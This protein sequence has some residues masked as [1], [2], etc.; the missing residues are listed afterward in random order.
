MIDN[1]P[2]LDTVNSLL[3]KHQQFISHDIENIEVF[4]FMH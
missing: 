4:Q 1:Y 2:H 3:T